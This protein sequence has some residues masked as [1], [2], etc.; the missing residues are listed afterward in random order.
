MRKER[1]IL[2]ILSDEDKKL[3]KSIGIYKIT[4]TIN[5]KFYIGSCD[6]NFSERFKEH[7][8]YYFQSK[9][10]RCKIHHP[11]LWSAYDKYGIENFSVE[12]LEILDGCSHKEILEKEESYITTL[13]PEY[14]ICK[15]PTKGGK[16]NKGRKLSEKWK[17]NIGIKSSKY[18]H[19]EETLKI[20]SENNKNNGSKVKFIKDDEELFFKTWVEAGEYF[21]VTP[22]SIQNSYKRTGKYKNYVIEKLTSQSKKIKVFIEEKEIIFDSF[23][24][25]DKHFDMWRGYTSTLINKKDGDKLIIDKYTYELV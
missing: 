20:I 8:A 25:C 18:T 1:K 19:S 22:S 11:V 9:E 17:T 23:N 2:F 12:I 5:S 24:K 14:N 3:L 6:R 10:G 21:N 15:H 13:N 7:C 4:N 16:P